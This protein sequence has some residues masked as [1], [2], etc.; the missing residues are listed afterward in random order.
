MAG[1]HY[2]MP[3]QETNKKSEVIILFYPKFY[4]DRNSRVNRHDFSV[5]KVLGWYHCANCIPKATVQKPL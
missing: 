1:Q 3:N 2:A 5:L 4:S